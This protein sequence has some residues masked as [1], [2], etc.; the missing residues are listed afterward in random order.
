MEG[1]VKSFAGGVRR[2]TL[3]EPLVEGGPE[4]VQRG[5]RGGPE[6]VSSRS[7]SCSAA[8][9]KNDSPPPHTNP[10]PRTRAHHAHGSRRA[11]IHPLRT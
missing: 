11:R 10:H 4:G 2:R 8:F 1:G 5:S 3:F 9:G 6:G 7:S